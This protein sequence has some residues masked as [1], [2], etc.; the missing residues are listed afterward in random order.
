MASIEMQP[1]GVVRSPLKTLADCPRQGAEAGVEAEIELEDRWAPG[2]QGLT[3][4]QSLWVIGHLHQ[5]GEPSLSVHP[6]GDP[7]QPKTGLFNTR[8][9]NRACPLSLNLV[10]VLAVQGSRLKV[11]GLEL[12]DGTPVLDIKPYAP[13]LDVPQGREGS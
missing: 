3:P 1:I 2:L 8:S 4:G 7:S 11:R 5:A 6:R 13:S 10:Q 9:P 12:V